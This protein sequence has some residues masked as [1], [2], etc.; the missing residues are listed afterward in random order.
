[1]GAVTAPGGHPEKLYVEV[2]RPRVYPQ[3]KPQDFLGDAFHYVTKPADIDPV[4][5]RLQAQGAQFVKIMVLYSEEYAKRKD[6]PAFYGLRGLDPAV[7]APLVRAAHARGLRVAAH[8]ETAHDFRVIVAAGVD[9]SAHM[10]GYLGLGDDI[11]RYR[12][13]D[14]DARAAAR[15]R[16]VVVTT[17]WLGGEDNEKNPSRLALIQA[18]QRSNLT[19]LKAAGVPLLIGTDGQPDAAPMEASYLIGLGVLSPTEALQ[20]LTQATP[21][22]IFPGRRIGR[23][24]PGYEASFL[25]LGGD[26]R[27]DFRATGDIRRRVKQGFDIPAP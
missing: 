25:V 15:A 13:T 6:D 7:V 12:I 1:M 22:W 26:P 24:S 3:I 27:V 4:L 19:K 9:E 18:M 23:L 11:D 5:D 2:L 16:M 20:T 8:I 21:Q 17:A 14:Q 10:P